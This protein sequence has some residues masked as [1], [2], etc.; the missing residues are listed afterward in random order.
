MQRRCQSPRAA[1]NG[2]TPRLRNLDVGARVKK[3]E[4]WSY[5]KTLQFFAMIDTVGSEG[6][7]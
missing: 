6:T 2:L 3:S 5:A 7:A 4:S 1:E